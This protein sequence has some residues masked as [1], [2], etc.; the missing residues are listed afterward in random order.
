MQSQSTVF[1]HLSHWA[2]NVWVTPLGNEKFSIPHACVA[3]FKGCLSRPAGPWRV[4]LDGEWSGSICR[5]LGKQ[6]ATQAAPPFCMTRGVGRLS[7]CR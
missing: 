4:M 3:L 2:A 6:A 5:P 7:Y 1:H